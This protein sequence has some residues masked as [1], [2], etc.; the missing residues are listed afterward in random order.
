MKTGIRLVWAVALLWLCQLAGAAAMSQS[1]IPTKFNIPFGNGAGGPYI[2]NIPQ[3]SQIGIQNCA[4]SLTDGFPPLT[5]VPAAAG[6]CPPFGQDMNG[7]LRQI[8]QWNVWMQAVSGLPYDAA[9]SAA[10]SGYPK[11]AIVQST[12]LQG[13]LWYST[14]DNNTTNPDSTAGSSAGWIVLPGTYAPGVPIPVLSASSPPPNAV[15][16]NGLTV[17]NASSNAT[18]RANTDTFWLF[19][20]LWS[21]CSSCVLYN[22]SGSVVSRGASAAADFAANY[23]VQALNL[24]GTA[25]VGADSM[26]GTTSS[27]L[28]NA[29]VV[30]GSRTVPGSILG[31][32]QHQ[33]TGAELPVTTPTFSGNAVTPTFSGNAVTP[34]FS[35]STGTVNVSS[36]QPNIVVGPLTASTTGGGGFN[37]LWPAALGITVNSSGS[38]TPAGSVSTIVP[39]GAVSTITPSGSISSFG[40]NGAHNNVERSAVV[41]WYLSL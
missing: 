32:N 18:N 20:F 16:A 13:R 31:E 12:V 6:G 28:A 33:L 27:L 35:G 39:S 9:F 26:A 19:S 8:T 40:S 11:G 24:N 25:L 29:P 2:R 15:P 3:S 37:F 34:T 30:S 14:A 5:F 36:T 21:N 4:A 22:S 41:Y 7:I 23:A 38:F 17:G 10:V 1:Q